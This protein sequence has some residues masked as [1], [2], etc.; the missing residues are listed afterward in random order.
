ML[1]QL[2]LTAAMALVAAV[3]AVWHPGLA[4]DPLFRT[5]MLAQAVLLALAAAVP[6]HRLPASAA[7]AVPVLHFVPIG[8]VRL[9]GLHS[10]MQ[11][12][13]L[14]VIPVVW[15]AWSG[16]HPRFC[17]ATTFLAPLLM[18]WAPL[19]AAGS[20]DAGA[21]ADVLVLPAMMLAAGTVVHM[22][23]TSTAEQRRSLERARDHLREALE[24]KA[25]ETRLLD[26]VLETIPVGVQAI[27]A[28]GATAVANRQQLLN[29]ALAGRVPG[30]G[31]EWPRMFAP[32]GSRLVLPK[33]PVM[34]ALRGEAFSDYIV[35]L[36]DGPSQ[37]VF[38]T[39]AR[40]IPTP[41]GGT[42]GS[43]L[44]FT[45]VTALIE[46]LAAK[47]AFLSNVSHE[48]R[49]PL[50]SVLG[51]VDLLLKAPGLPA[52]A[53]DGLEVVR[54]NA[55]RLQRLVTDLLTAAAGAVDARPE[56][57]DMAEIVRLAVATAADAAEAASVSLTDLT[58]H[59]P[60][61][62]MLD[63]V[64]IAQLLDN[65]LSNAIKYT[66]PG[67]RVTVRAFRARG[68][69]ACEV[70]DTGIGMTGED[71]E[72]IFTRFYRAE[73]ARQ[74]HIPGIGLGLAIAKSIVDAHAG[75]IACTSRPGAGTTF[76][77]LLPD[78]PADP[79]RQDPQTHSPAAGRERRDREDS[80]AR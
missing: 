55:Q 32:D 28:H 67:G 19:A 74:D 66:R 37:R 49:T 58:E 52:H 1:G 59:R 39:S 47:D 57:A 15:L 2:P 75:R 12:G 71:T 42:D 6:W 44:A 46:A 10:P 21:Y 73:T 77:V 30:V 17:L 33:Q 36:G 78:L 22:L 18:V 69:I 53:R 79:A 11:L 51:Y 35:R 25:R 45:D 68:G 60:L 7:L 26:T 4:G 56:P 62:A 65:L 40:P 13:V 29:K 14:A 8:M 70:A 20:G 50:T 64:R 54:R 72:R 3:A 80:R 27:D 24:A 41:E 31:N 48:L 16:L 5:G 34:R 76:T 43:V 61:P 23:A 9:A 38:S 63:P